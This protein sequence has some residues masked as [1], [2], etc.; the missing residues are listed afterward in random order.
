[1]RAFTILISNSYGQ[2]TEC[3]E[4]LGNIPASQ[5]LQALF[6]LGRLNPSYGYFLGIMVGGNIV[7]IAEINDGTP[8][9]LYVIGG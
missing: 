4:V 1:M 5:A 6:D 8:S 2:M 3:T 7:R 9:T